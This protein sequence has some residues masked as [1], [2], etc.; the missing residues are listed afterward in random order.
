MLNKRR[1]AALALTATTAAAVT[2]VPSADAA[3]VGK[4]ENG[5]CSLQ[6]SIAEKDFAAALPRDL[7]SPQAQQKQQWT[8]A[9]EVAFPEAAPIAQEF[10]EA[11][12][13][14]YFRPVSYTHLTLPTIQL[15]C[16]SRWSPYH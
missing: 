3:T 7:R 8:N 14:P 9:F 12:N 11:F 4:P 5:V 15:S 10:L 6:M 1:I 13:G 2:A 16:R